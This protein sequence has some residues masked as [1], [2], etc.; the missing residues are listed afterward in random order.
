M[1]FAADARAGPMA[2]H[3][4]RTL[5]GTDHAQPEDEFK[6]AAEPEGLKGLIFQEAWS[7]S[8]EEMQ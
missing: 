3:D 2:G 1:D 6:A 5:T 8:D 4:S 7:I